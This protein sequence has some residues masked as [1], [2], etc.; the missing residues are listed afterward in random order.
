MESRAEQEKNSMDRMSDESTR[1]SENDLNR[2]ADT[3][4]YWDTQSVSFILYPYYSKTKY[5]RSE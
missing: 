3:L 2:I 4:V 5:I 1:N